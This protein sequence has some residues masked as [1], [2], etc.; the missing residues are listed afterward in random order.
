MVKGVNSS[1]IYLIH[2]KNLCKR[3][4]VPQSSTTIKEK[5]TQDK[6]MLTLHIRGKTT[7]SL[8]HLDFYYINYFRAS[9]FT[10][11]RVMLVTPHRRSAFCGVSLLWV[12][13]VL[14]FEFRA[15]LLLSRCSTT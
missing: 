9:I 1:M 13:V 15:S 4:N 6:L 7:A 14:G 10:L 8:K 3:H 11:G 12:V 2:Y 5:K